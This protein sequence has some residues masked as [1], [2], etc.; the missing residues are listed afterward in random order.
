MMQGWLVTVIMTLSH[1]K[2][3][4]VCLELCTP[5]Y[6]L[7]PQLHFDTN[8]IFGSLLVAEILAHHFF[9]PSGKFLRKWRI[10]VRISTILPLHDAS[11]SAKIC[12]MVIG[13]PFT[14]WWIVDKRSSFRY[15]GQNQ[16]NDPTVTFLPIL[17][18]FSRV[19]RL[20]T[21]LDVMGCT[22]NVNQSVIIRILSLGN[23]ERC[24]SQLHWVAQFPP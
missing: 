2:L 7:H 23:V 21:V 11:K 15:L 5:A 9:C 3:H 19:M 12:P 4:L 17:C 20:N 16:K 6:S 18:N 13:C 10:Y 22:M 24:F 1:K 8:L 14:S